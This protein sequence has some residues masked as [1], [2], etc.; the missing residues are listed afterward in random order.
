MHV[1][2]LNGR[3]PVEQK[4]ARRLK[5]TVLFVPR[6]KDREFYRYW[7]RQH[8]NQGNITLP[9]NATRSSHA[10]DALHPG[11]PPIYQA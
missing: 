2:N 5:T 7:N 3:I 9:D 10:I 11:L 4:E 8:F 6:L 1:V